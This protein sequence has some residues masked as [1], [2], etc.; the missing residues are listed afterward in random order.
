MKTSRKI[1]ISSVLFAAIALPTIA[2]AGGPG[3]LPRRRLRRHRR[4]AV[5]F[6]AR[7]G[8]S[9]ARDFRSLLSAMALTGSCGV[10][11]ASRTSLRRKHYTHIQTKGRRKSSSKIHCEASA[12]P[13]RVSLGFFRTRIQ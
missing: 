8:Q 6:T 12:D 13:P 11:V 4:P 3:Q 1:T 7:R 10:I 5:L 2:I 9:L